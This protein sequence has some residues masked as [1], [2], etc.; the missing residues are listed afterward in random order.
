MHKLEKA[1]N[2]GANMRIHEE[3]L[4]GNVYKINLEGRMDIP[5]TQE[6]DLKFTGMTAAPRKAFIVDISGV[7]FLASIGIRTLLINTKAINNRGGK[8]VILN[9]DANVEK[10]LLMA[11][12]DTLIP[13]FNDLELALAA[14]N[15]VN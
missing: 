13:I 11:G 7:D 14:V 5:G 3:Q 8:L 10:I 15:Q 6:I 12:I 2:Y 1:L 4:E 9:P